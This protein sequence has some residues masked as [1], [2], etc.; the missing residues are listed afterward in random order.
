[1]LLP[2]ADIFALLSHFAPLF[3]RRVWRHI[4]L[5]VVGAILAPGHRMVSTVLRTVGLS[6]DQ[7][8][9]TYH[10]VLNRA[11]WSSLKASH[12]LL[13]LLVSTFVPTG[14]VVLGIDET[15]ERRRGAKIAATGIYRGPVRSSHSHFV[16]VNGLRWV[17][18]ML[19]VPIPWAARVWALPFL[20]ALAP[21]ERNAQLH[22]RQHKP[23][24]LWARQL[25]RLVHR[26]LPTRSLVVV[27]DRGYAALDLLDAVRP[28]ATVITR[29]RLDA[30]LVAPAPPR[31]PH[32]TGRPR[33]VGHR[34]PTLDQV[35]AHPATVWTAVTLTRWYGDRDRTIEYVSQTAVWYHT[36]FV[37]V[38]IRWVLTRDPLGRFAT[39]ALLCTDLEADPV[40]ILIWFAR[41]WQMEVTFHEVRAHLGVETQ[42]QWSERAI[43]RT[44]P[45]LLGLFSLVTL[46]AHDHHHQGSTRPEP[47]R[48]AAWYTKATPTFS[49]ALALVRRHLWTQSTFPT[50]PRDRDVEKVPRALLTHLADLLCY[51]A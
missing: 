34:L 19:L 3:S 43:A 14:P 44:T 10:R 22:G 20:S 11:V 50:S 28:V 26:W 25:I 8:F 36:G 38:P 21:S 48:V 31:L 49:D 37:P 40:Q 42:R 18:L 46:L 24:T 45:A 9:Q 2:P 47:V 35:R 39:Q 27:G 30:R 12:I 17:C 6:Q 23:V 4:P 41:R 5:L 1:M 29:L 51:A 16:K 15:I 7:H 33:I 32:Q 13:R